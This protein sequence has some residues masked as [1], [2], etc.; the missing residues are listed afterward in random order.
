MKSVLNI[1][2]I[3]TLP[4][5]IRALDKWETEMFK[6]GTAIRPTISMLTMLLMLICISCNQP[7]ENAD[8]PYAHMTN[9]IP[10]TDTM[11]SVSAA[12]PLSSSIESSSIGNKDTAK[13]KYDTVDLK[14]IN[15]PAYVNHVK[16]EVQKDVNV[17][18]RKIKQVKDSVLPNASKTIITKDE[19]VT[20]TDNPDGSVQVDKSSIA[21]SQKLKSPKAPKTHKLG[22]DGSDQRKRLSV[23]PV[24][25]TDERTRE[26]S[27]CGCTQKIK[28]TAGMTLTSV[29]KRYGKSLPG[30]SPT[31]LRAINKPT[32]VTDDLK[33][34][35]GGMFLC[36]KRAKC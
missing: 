18:K 30:L 20:I 26:L 24:R 32:V 23:G 19:S 22:E 2:S 28:T 9:G 5:A 12:L 4:A 17:L 1:A 27:D 14:A 11:S 36:L 25:D 34:T 13:I 8:N 3:F 10:E 31:W 35:K 33:I 29:V 21:S 16:E 6:T 7:K 15:T